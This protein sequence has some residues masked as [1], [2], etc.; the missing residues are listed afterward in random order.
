ML[1]SEPTTALLLARFRRAVSLR[2]ALLRTEPW[3][4]REGERIRAMARELGIPDRR[5]TDAAA[6]LSPAGR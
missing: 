6:V 3:Y 4:W 5:A 1:H 2:P